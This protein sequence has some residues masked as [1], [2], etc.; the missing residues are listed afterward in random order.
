MSNSVHGSKLG[1]AIVL[2]CSLLTGCWERRSGLS[3]I[4]EESNQYYKDIATNI[5]F[6]DETQEIPEQVVNSAKPRTIR[7]R[8]KEREFTAEDVWEMP[9]SE[10]IETAIQNNRIIRSDATFLSPGNALYTNP[11]RV[12][13]V[14]DPAIQESGVLF[15]GRG[16]EA[17]LSAFDARW[18]TSLLWGRN[19]NYNNNAFAPGT[20][21]TAETANFETSLTKAFGYGGQVSLGHNVDYLGSNSPNLLFPSTYSGS[22]GAQYRQPLLAGAGAEYTRIAGPITQSFGGITGVNQ[23][24]VIARINNDITIADLENNV[25][26]LVLDVEQLY[27]E[28]YLGYVQYDTA[29]QAR[30][31]ARETWYNNLRRRNAENDKPL[32]FED[33]LLAPEGEEIQRTSLQITQGPD[34]PDYTGGEYQARDAYYQ[35]VVVVEQSLS[36]IYS[37]EN[38][39]RR[40]LGLQVNDGRIIRPKD[41]PLTAEYT[42][43]WYDAIADGLT[44]RP[45]LRRQKW[46]VKSL[47]L[48]LTAAKSLTRPR[49]DFV[50]NARLNGV[51]D[52][53]FGT[54]RGDGVSGAGLDNL[55]GTLGGGDTSGWGAGFEMS[56][57]IGYRSA[58]AQ[59]RNIELRLS[60]AREVLSVQEMD[61]SHEIAASMQE[62][63]LAHQ[64]MKSLYNRRIAAKQFVEHERNRWNVQGGSTDLLLRAIRSRAD[65]DLAYYRSLVQYNQSLARF[66]F[67]KGTLLE[68]NNV[69]LAEDH[70]DPEA[71]NDALRR[72]QERGH[73]IEDNLI[74]AKPAPFSMGPINPQ[75]VELR[76]PADTPDLPLEPPVEG[77]P[78]SP[79]EPVLAPPI[80]DEANERPYDET[81]VSL[82]PPRKT[83]SLRPVPDSTI[84]S[85]SVTNTLAQQVSPQPRSQPTPHSATLQT[86]SHESGTTHPETQS[87]EIAT[88]SVQVMNAAF[89]TEPVSNPVN[90]ATIPRVPQTEPL[91]QWPGTA[92]REKQTQAPAPKVPFP[93][94]TSRPKKI[95]NTESEGEWFPLD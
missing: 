34:K 92:N 63:A 45:E 61:I 14:Y 93:R 9:L 31:S 32:D 33:P 6:P 38:R 35:S 94:N 84:L 71:Y 70:W 44:N 10:A 18:D 29:V 89:G 4:G 19:S 25:R 11:D 15:G 28:L 13:S 51:G 53:L 49:L 91:P 52:D 56:I 40:L 65:A 77:F 67:R 20:A 74:E 55:Y 72:A 58:L 23:G 66:Q 90:R 86:V 64:N 1:L 76:Q 88:P 26:N 39:L 7:D 37:T 3:F 59:V 41:N 36:E 5:E 46:N 30:E 8:N 82:G 54:D 12:A 48:Q 43:N 22:L 78:P 95:E 42:P 83:L 16:I 62:L 2:S 79:D 68:Y 73:A 85:R 50:T 24:V 81:S 60:K 57:P 47:E 27:W 87:P 21:S 17:A 80:T 75:Q 69:Y